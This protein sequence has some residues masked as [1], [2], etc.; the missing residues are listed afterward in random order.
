MAEK[1]PLQFVIEDCIEAKGSQRHLKPEDTITLCQQTQEITFN[2]A[3][4]GQNDIQRRFDGRRFPREGDFRAEWREVDVAPG[5]SLLV[6][7]LGHKGAGDID[8]D[9]DD[10]DIFV[11]VGTPPDG[12]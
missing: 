2:R 7:F 11:A 3:H 9:D 10:M 5:I 12:G 8:D 6:G 4:R 1:K